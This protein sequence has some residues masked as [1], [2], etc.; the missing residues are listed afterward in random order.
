MDGRFDLKAPRYSSPQWYNALSIAVEQVQKE[1][2]EEKANAAELDAYQR[3]QTAGIMLLAQIVASLVG[4]KPFAQAK[5]LG[6]K[7]AS[8]EAAMLVKQT[9][10]SIEEVNKEAAERAE[11]AKT[12]SVDASVNAWQN[13]FG[14]RGA[15]S[16]ETAIKN[17]QNI[18]LSMIAQSDAEKKKN[19]PAPITRPKRGK[20]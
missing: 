7:F 15:D 4:E 1:E 17:T 5:E 18:L 2:A 3:F 8:F 19:A 16:T 10:K 13:I 20:R 9:G 6:E 11:K 14:K 12:A